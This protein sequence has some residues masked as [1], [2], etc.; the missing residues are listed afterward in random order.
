[1]RQWRGTRSLPDAMLLFAPGFL[2]L[3]Y[4]AIT[5]RQRVAFHWIAAGIVPWFL[6]LARRY[7]DRPRF[8]RWSGGVSAALA[9]GALILVRFPDAIPEPRHPFARMKATVA[10]RQLLG[11]EEAGA[12]WAEEIRGVEAQGRRVFLLGDDYGFLCQG[13]FEGR[14]G[15]V[16]A[17][18]R[19]YPRR[20]GGAF[21]SWMQE[22]EP[23]LIGADAIYMKADQRPN[24][25]RPATPVDTQRDKAVAEVAD[26]FDAVEVAP[27]L[28]VMRD[29]TEFRRF[30]VLRCRGYRGGFAT[31]RP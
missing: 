27:D 5:F 12:R 8:L 21:R 23:R 19:R 20:E 9:I 11:I 15:D 25:D 29:G 2:V 1:V 22:D 7:A 26:R 6:A 13:W 3:G 24:R 30:F 16:P 18:W 4:V 10:R 17:M 31:P 14:L 28:V